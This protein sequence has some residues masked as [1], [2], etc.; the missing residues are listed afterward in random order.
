MTTTAIGDFFPTKWI[1]GDY[2]RSLFAGIVQQ[3]EQ[4]FPDTNNVVFSLTW[5]GPQTLEAIERVPRPVDNLFLV[6]TVD[7]PTHRAADY[8]KIMQPNT[9]YK[10][11]NFD[12]P[13]EFNF[14][15]IVCRDHFRHY[16][17]DDLILRELRWRY[18]AYNRKPYT[19]RVHMVRELVQQGLE[20]HGVITLGRAFPGEPD[21]GLYRTI[22]ERNED[23]V[24]WGHWYDEGGTS[25]D[26][27][28]DLFSLHNWTVWQHHFL[29]IIG[30]T[31][32]FNEADT[33]INQIHFK[34]LIGMRPFVINGQPKQ[35]EYLRRNGFH[36][37][38]QY[39]PK[40]WKEH[41]YYSDNTL[42]L[43]IANLVKWLVSLS[44]Q[45]VMAMYNDML[46]QLIHNRNRWFEYA[47][48]Q[49]HRAG[50]L[51]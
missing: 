28:H 21:H 7:P 27:P 1:Y 10:L 30:C 15:A 32:P 35:Y 23:Y 39:W 49:K 48:Q 33:Y 5:D 46:P 51:F 11:G 4:H 31:E 26:I 9:V 37:F 16:E 19:H 47:D 43:S 50:S 13:Y 40:F 17:T 12:S 20:P 6:A 3:V 44:D 8:I 36:T 22:G 42:A 38:E 18:C 24:R 2:E 34:P 29:H 14:F 25:H 45:E 41:S